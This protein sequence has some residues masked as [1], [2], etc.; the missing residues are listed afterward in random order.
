M[1]WSQMRNYPLSS[2]ASFLS[3]LRLYSPHACP[4]F[5][6]ARLRD[7]RDEYTHRDDDVVSFPAV[8][9]REC[10]VKSVPI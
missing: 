1:T 6:V 5:S 9:L 3:D 10:G 2:R 8:S 7:K 4:R